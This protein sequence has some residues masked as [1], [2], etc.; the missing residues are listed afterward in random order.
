MMK[1]AEVI[2]E[3]GHCYSSNIAFYVS[4]KTAVAF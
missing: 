1:V 4:G 2:F 3:T